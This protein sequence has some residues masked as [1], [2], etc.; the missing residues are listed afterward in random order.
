MRLIYLT[1]LTA[2]SLNAQAYCSPSAIATSLSATYIAC[3]TSPRIERLDRSQPIPTAGPVS[4]ILASADGRL[5]YA[6]LP[7]PLSR[8]AVIDTGTGK[9]IRTLPAGHTAVFLVLRENRLYV[10]NQFSNDVSV[11]DLQSGKEA[12]RL[13]AIREPLGAA[14]SHDGRTLLVINSVPAGRA[15]AEYIAASVSV[16]D[17]QQLRPAGVIELPNGSS[18]LRAIAVTPD[19]AYAAVTHL[20]ARYYLPTTQLDR[21]W[22]ETNAL[23]IIDVRNRTLA[24]TVLLDAPDRG[25]AN[26][27]AVQFSPDARL[28]AVTHAGTHELSVIDFAGLLSK[29]QFQRT[30][31]KPWDDMSFLAGLRL[32]WPLQGNGPRAMTLTST[33]AVIG[34]YFSDTMEQVEL[35]TGKSTVA[36]RLST[37]PPTVIRNGERIFNDGSLCFQ[38][39]QSCASCHTPDARV[40][41]LNWDLMNDGLGNPKNVKSLLLAH[42]TPPAMSHGVRGS[43]ELAVRAGIRY[44]LFTERPEAEAMAIDEFLKALRPIPSPLL[45]NGSLSPSARRGKALFFDSKTACATCH[46]A[47]LYTDLKTYDVGTRS[48]TD[49]SGEFDTPTLVEIWR[50]GPY[51]HNGSAATMLDVF[52]LFN[53]QDKHGKTSHLTEAQ[54]HDLV[55]FLMSL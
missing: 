15:D 19:G 3:A 20:V 24:G 6:A 14:L 51:L 33:A 52:T 44:I 26:P 18:E 27:W 23:S 22:M 2:A 45:V 36:R 40:D 54:L 30:D 16:F 17:T 55:E 42:R 50:T 35:L 5:L 38:G 48:S 1:L 8:V 34:N 25:A 28:L 12:A 53:K 9:T 11:L 39:W 41:G 37:A 31:R 7:A 10:V 32:R 47:G 13:K 21:G 43:A 29:L 46:P 49:P 4:H